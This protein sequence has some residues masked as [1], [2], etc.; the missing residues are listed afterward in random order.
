MHLKSLVMGKIKIG[1][2]GKFPVNCL[3][4]SSLDSWLQPERM[5][6][7]WFIVPFRWG[8]WGA[9]K[10]NTELLRVVIHVFLRQR[11]SEITLSRYFRLLK[12]VKGYCTLIVCRFSHTTY[13]YIDKD[14]SAPSCHGIV[15]FLQERKKPWSE[16][17]KVHGTLLSIAKNKLDRERKPMSATFCSS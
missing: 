10:Y 11:T 3:W 9:F 14:S 7:F 8:W 17:V 2:E 6:Y 13:S 4:I 16:R 5:E 12:L 15:E 1:E